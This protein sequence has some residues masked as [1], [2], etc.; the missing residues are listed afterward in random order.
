MILPNHGSCQSSNLSKGID[1]LSQ[2]VYLI[3]RMARYI[4]RIINTPG[5]L[6]LYGVECRLPGL[7]LG[8]LLLGGCNAIQS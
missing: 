6:C 8:C 3:K 4:R 5:E 1:K 2:M 7:L